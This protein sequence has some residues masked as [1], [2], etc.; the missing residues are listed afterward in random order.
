[1]TLRSL[2]SRTNNRLQGRIDV[3]YVNKLD[4]RIDA[5]FFDRYG[6]AMAR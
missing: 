3:M 2:G 5:G 6:R 1:M 4:W